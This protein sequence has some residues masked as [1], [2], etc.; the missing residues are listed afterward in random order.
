MQTLRTDSIRSTAIIS[1]TDRRGLTL[2]QRSVL[3]LVEVNPGLADHRRRRQLV[4][5]LNLFDLAWDGKKVERV[6]EELVVLRTNG[7]LQ[8]DAFGPAS[9]N[10]T[11][12]PKRAAQAVNGVALLSGWGQLSAEMT[13]T[14]KSLAM[15][16]L[17]EECPASSSIMHRKRHSRA[18]PHGEVNAGNQQPDACGCPWPE[19]SSEGPHVFTSLSDLEQCALSLIHL[20]P[21]L[22]H[23]RQ[24]PRLRLLMNM[25]S[26]EFDHRR[27]GKAITRLENLNTSRGI[28]TRGFMRPCEVAPDEDL[29]VRVLHAL[30]RHSGWK[31]STETPH[32]PWWRQAMLLFG[33]ERSRV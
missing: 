26:P 33:H 21:R 25:L 31:D 16:L 29:T 7:Q 27:V 24:R 15:R 9:R 32:P 11:V 23:L 2:E 5:L 6:L 20:D 1:T 4:E 10:R 22:T 18:V 19:D 8:T 12:D 28:D 17:T 3:A 30:A 13:V 14:K